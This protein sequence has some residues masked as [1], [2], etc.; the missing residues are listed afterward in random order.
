MGSQLNTVFADPLPGKPPYR[1][2]TY[3][4]P[5]AIAA[6]PGLVAWWEPWPAA[7]VTLAST[8]VTSIAPRYGTGNMVPTSIARRPTLAAAAL[9]GRDAF[10]FDRTASDSF[11][12]SGATLNMDT[13]DFTVVSL[14]KA[15]SATAGQTVAGRQ[16]DTNN[17]FAM[18]HI[19]AQ[20]LRTT[21]GSTA[22]TADLPC[23]SGAWHL[24]IGGRSKTAGLARLFLDGATVSVAA[25][26]DVGP[27]TSDLVIGAVN[28]AGGS[29]FGGD[30]ALFMAFQ[31]D[32]FVQAGAINLIRKYVA[33]VYGLT[34]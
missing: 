11:V 32:L 21:F 34:W 10:R 3:S 5:G 31:S 14:F 29:P 8:E 7:N 28:T 23:A 24:A 33:F 16:T 19:N 22:N 1:L 18:W 9:N 27:T 26:S 13:A 6:L 12:L 17:R 25:A 30:Q 15:D 2:T 20:Q 4:L